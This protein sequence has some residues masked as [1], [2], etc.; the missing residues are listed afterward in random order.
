MR[1]YLVSISIIFSLIIFTSGCKPPQN[2]ITQNTTLDVCVMDPL[3]QQKMVLAHRGTGNFN[4]WATENTIAAF[5]IA[6]RMGADS[7]ETDVRKTS[8]G[9]L[10]IMHDST[11]DKTTNGSGRVED[12]T[13]AQIKGL[14][15]RS[16]NISVPVQSVPTFMETLSFIKGKT[17][18]D[19][20]LKT[21]D[22]EAVVSEITSAGMIDSAYIVLGSPAEAYAARSI[23]PAVAIMPKVQNVEEA[24]EFVEN[25]SPVAFFEIE[26]ANATPELVEYIHSNGIK[27]HMNALLNYDFLGETG[28]DMLLERGADIIQTDRVELLVPY[29]R[30]L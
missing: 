5:D 18:L 8:D 26:Y 28:Y 27:V 29:L 9:Y 13:L 1:K 10:V 4:F 11:V 19:V 2:T 21:N 3:C 23:N 24:R 30:G 25:L 20:D 22:I 12:M 14:K 17:L 6:W 15:I 16:F 7:I